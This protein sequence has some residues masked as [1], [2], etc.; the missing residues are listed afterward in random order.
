MHAL[1]YED[2]KKGIKG[3]SLLSRNTHIV[4]KVD[5]KEITLTPS[6]TFP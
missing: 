1:S 5:P 6:S 3:V 2:K 4:G